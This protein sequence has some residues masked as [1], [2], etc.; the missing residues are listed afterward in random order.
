MQFNLHAAQICSQPFCHFTKKLKTSIEQMLLQKRM[1][2]GP[3]NSAGVTEYRST[4]IFLSCTRIDDL[5]S[6]SDCV[7]ESTHCTVQIITVL[8]KKVL[9]K[10]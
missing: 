3:L 4:S 9:L 2:R 7:G 1:E 5:R 10:S 6:F 8:G